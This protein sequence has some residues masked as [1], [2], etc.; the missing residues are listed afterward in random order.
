MADLYDPTA[1]PPELVKAHTALDRAVDRCY[2]SRTFGGDRERVEFLFE[3]Y[4]RLNTPL[5]AAVTKPKRGRR[6][7]EE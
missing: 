4:E 2:G 5:T 7:A 3:M 1:M 6:A